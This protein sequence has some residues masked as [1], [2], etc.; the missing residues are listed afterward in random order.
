MEPGNSQTIR[1]FISS[2]GDVAAERDKAKQVVA[3]LQKWY[4]PA[5]RLVPV[6][7]EEL[8]LEIDASFQNG[9]DVILSGNQGIDIAVFII[10]SR[11]GT[12]VT[13]GGRTYGETVGCEKREG[14]N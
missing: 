9:I 8:P 2:P 12:P 14:K 5:V 1:I 11:I 7:W 4:G 10:W 13:I 3:Q 6:L